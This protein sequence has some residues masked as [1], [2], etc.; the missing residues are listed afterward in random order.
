MSPR[1]QWGLLLVAFAILLSHV[2]ARP[3][4]AHDAVP[5]S[6]TS[7]AHDPDTESDAVHAASCEAL[8]PDGTSA[9]PLASS[10]AAFDRL[11]LAVPAGSVTCGP[12]PRPTTS[13]PLFL[14]HAA[15]LI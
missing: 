5:A 14:L 7:H 13:P 4:H 6:H 10:H 15:L 11:R 2:C 8:K 3:T 12:V 9:V 1:A